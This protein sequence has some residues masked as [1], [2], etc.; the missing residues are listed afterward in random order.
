MATNLESAFGLCQL[1]HPVIKA[2][3]GGSI[4]F[5]SSVAGGPTTMKCAHT[6][7]WCLRMLHVCL[8]PVRQV[9]WAKPGG[10][11]GHKGEPAR[12]AALFHHPHGLATMTLSLCV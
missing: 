10:V 1:V 2:S 4:I 8:S 6:D 9:F 11:A 7:R 12:L 3:G 5:N